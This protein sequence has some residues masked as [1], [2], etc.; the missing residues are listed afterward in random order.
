MLLENMYKGW[1]GQQSVK[2]ASNQQKLYTNLVACYGE[3]ENLC[4]VSV[5][6]TV[7][8]SCTFVYNA[9]GVKKIATTFLVK[10]QP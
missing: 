4:F 6:W 8:V 7:S 3:L 2:K 1:W 9:V 5:A 10:P